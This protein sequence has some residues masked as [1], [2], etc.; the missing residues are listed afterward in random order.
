MFIKFTY[1]LPVQLFPQQLEHLLVL[2]VVQ[3]KTLHYY[4]SVTSEGL[5][6]SHHEGRTG[7]HE[8]DEHED[9]YYNMTHTW[10][11]PSKTQD[12]AISYT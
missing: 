8:D 4:P 6:H 10:Y 9:P 7:S 1:V 3:C 12:I 5:Q 2:Q 11:N